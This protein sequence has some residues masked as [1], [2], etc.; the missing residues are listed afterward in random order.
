MQR[1]LQLSAFLLAAFVL[2]PG[3]ITGGGGSKFK[4]PKKVNAIIQ[5]KCYGC[6]SADSKAQKAKDKLM[7]D[8]LAGMSAEQQLDKMKNIQKVLDKG[9]MPPERFLEKMPEKKLTDK[10]SA[11]M[12]KWA[13]KMTKKLGK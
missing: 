9:S 7:W 13:S 1:T 3:F 12:K 8:D 6:H 11:T 2:L 5:D 10:E 4:I